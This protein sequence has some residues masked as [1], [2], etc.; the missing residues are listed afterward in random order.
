MQLAIPDY[1]AS[2][3]LMGYQALVYLAL[4]AFP[5]KQ[6]PLALLEQLDKR[7][8]QARKVKWDVMV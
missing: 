2:M 6:V 1:L 7:V 5:A 3:V 8:Q 4:R